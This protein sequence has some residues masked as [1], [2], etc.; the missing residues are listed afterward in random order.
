MAFRIEWT[1][2]EQDYLRAVLLNHSRLKQTRLLVRVLMPLTL[3]LLLVYGALF[4][5]DGIFIAFVSAFLVV[6]AFHFG[7]RWYGLPRH[8][9][10]VFEQQRSLHLPM[11]LEITDE[12]IRA[13]SGDE[14]RSFLPWTDA[15]HWVEGERDVLVFPSDALFYMLPKERLQ[16]DELEELRGYLADTRKL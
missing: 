9:K 4:G 13:T 7:M 12:G 5:A 8:A 16:P 6:L 14:D 1:R 15:H 11:T 10:R 3:L 2:T